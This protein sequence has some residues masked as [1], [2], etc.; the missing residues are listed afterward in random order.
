MYV[1]GALKYS[2]NSSAVGGGESMPKLYGLWT[3]VDVG[4]SVEGEGVPSSLYLSH[5]HIRTCICHITYVVTWAHKGLHLS[6]I[7]YVCHMDT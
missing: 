4:L 5:P 6:H 3:H 2:V 1:A 7:T